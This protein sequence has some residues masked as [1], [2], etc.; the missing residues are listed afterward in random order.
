MTLVAF[1]V[2]S[3]TDAL[4]KLCAE[5][6]ASPQVTLGVTFAAFLL[7]CAHAVATGG[8]SRLLPRQ[9]GL[10]VLRA[11]LASCCSSATGF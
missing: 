8:L 11:V 4:V 10:A 6:L 7:L 9:P 5:R 1:A 3:G 2:F